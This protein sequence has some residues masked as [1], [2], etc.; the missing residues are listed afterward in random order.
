MT[1][2]GERD[3][4]LVDL[5]QRRLESIERAATASHGKIMAVSISHILLWVFVTF[6][7]PIAKWVGLFLLAM[8]FATLI[9]EYKNKAMVVGVDARMMRSNIPTDEGNPYVGLLE[10]MLSMAEA[11]SEILKDRSASIDIALTLLFAQ[12]LV[13][14][15]GYVFQ[16]GMNLWAYFF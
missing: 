10:P 1:P 5:T 9:D 6:N 7:T 2:Q 8:S 3:K 16:A 11:K 15:A 14:S 13:A 4:L 12:A